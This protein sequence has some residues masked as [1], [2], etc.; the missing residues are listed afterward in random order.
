MAASNEVT[1]KFS[2]D[3]SNLK[4]NIQEANRNIR[5]ANAEFKAA[6]AG[7]DNWR[8][9]SEGLSAKI[10]QLKSVLTSQKSVLESLKQQYEQVAAEQGANSKGAQELAIKIANQ[11]AAVNQTTQDLNKY[12]KELGNVEKAEALAAKNGKTVE[13]NLRDLGNEAK[14]TGE[15]V[16]K[17]SE[18]YSVLK[19][20]MAN[21]VSQ[22]IQFAASAMKELAKETWESVKAA[23]AFADE[24]NTLSA[25]TGLSTETLQEYKYMEDLIDVSTETMT[26]SMAKLIRNMANAQKGTGDAAAAFEALG[27]SVTDANGELRSNQDVFNEAIDALG[28]MENETQRDAYAMQIFG[29]SAQDLNPLITA[30]SEKIAALAQEAHDMGYVLDSE[31]LDSLNETQDALDRLSK[32]AEGAKN[33]IVAGL[34]PVVSSVLEPLAGA[35]ADLPAALKSGDFSG[36]FDTFRGVFEGAIQTAQDE[37]PAFIKAGINL[38]RQI[39]EGILGETPVMLETSALLLEAAMDGLSENLPQFIAFIP[40][41]LQ[42][43]F[44]VLINQAPALLKAGNGLALALIKSIAGNLLPTILQGL[45]GFIKTIADAALESAPEFLQAGQDFLTAILEGIQTALPLLLEAIPQIIETIMGLLE[46]GLPLIISAAV[47]MFTGVVDA[48]PQIVQMLIRNVPILITTATNIL[49]QSLPLIIEAAVTMLKGIIQAL[50]TIARLLV[51]DLPM[52]VSVITQTLIANLPLIISAALELLFGICMAMNELVPELV[53]QAPELV[54]AIVKGI[55]ESAGS[56]K[57]AGDNLVKGLWQGISGAKDWIKGKLTEW[58]GDV[59]GFVKDL[60][61]VHSPSTVFEK[62][63]GFQLPAGAALGV[64]K[65]TKALTS[66]LRNMASEAVEATNLSPYVSGAKAAIG[67]A[68]YA[69]APAA[70]SG[71][72]V[73]KVTNNTFNQYNTSPKALSRLEIYRQTNNQFNFAMGGA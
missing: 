72:N 61:G 46:Q 48:L 6:A 66:A 43:L 23:A 17:S 59:V 65:N 1:A 5:L 57:E 28:K 51:A 53:K 45:P 7:M 35:V 36:I 70:A 73:T 38:V 8:T 62:E 24:I 68:V 34:G 50:P 29:K 3:I 44:A 56:M 63:I 37:G 64:K 20:A 42:Q 11:Q 4:K 26:G 40:P 69:G 41:L 2:V 12:E 52:L 10:G 27:I 54:K 9:S 58:V 25:Q 13:E 21:L 60:F 39:A 33:S 32:V 49:V 14:E 16:E 55:E 30:G 47:V 19:G 71:G 22:G 15:K 18:G 31:A 67:S